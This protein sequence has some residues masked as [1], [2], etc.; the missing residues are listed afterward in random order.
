[1]TGCV[2][3]G[4]R[5]RRAA[6]TGAHPGPSLATRA[7]LAELTTSPYD[8]KLVNRGSVVKLPE[9]LRRTGTTARQVRYLISEKFI[10][11]PT[12]GRA[13]ASYSDDHVRA[14]QKYLKLRQLG[15]SPASIRALLGA[16]Q[17]VPV[18]TDAGITLIVPAELVGSG[19]DLEALL[20]PIRDALRET[21]TQE[22]G[23]ND[24]ES[25]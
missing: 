11:A 2:P 1:M 22:E 18:P 4:L 19:R 5:D 8:N 21:V 20:G 14:I 9:L 15:F 17:G 12:G 24:M 3:A 23:P 25:D 13:H 10:P 7:V 6:D 16:R